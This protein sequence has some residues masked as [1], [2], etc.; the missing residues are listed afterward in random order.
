MSPVMAA[1]DGDG[2][3]APPTAGQVDLGFHCMIMTMLFVLDF[4][5]KPSAQPHSL[6][7]D[8]GDLCHQGVVSSALISMLSDPQTHLVSR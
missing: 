6:R 3:G 7:G 2:G 4:S 1:G 8:T 5:I